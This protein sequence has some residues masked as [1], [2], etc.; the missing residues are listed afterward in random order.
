MD[1]AL[2]ARFLF[3]LRQEGRVGTNWS[4]LIVETFSSFGLFHESLSCEIFVNDNSWMFFYPKN[5]A[6]FFG[7]RNFLW[8]KYKGAQV[9]NL[10]L[11]VV[12]N[13]IAW[14]LNWCDVRIVKNCSKFGSE[15]TTIRLFL[16]CYIGV[17]SFLLY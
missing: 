7:S 14:V 2:V 15:T 11:F 3:V 5:F 17:K 8:L 1:F 13:I 10:F 4:T 9:R 12:N 16:S 6:S